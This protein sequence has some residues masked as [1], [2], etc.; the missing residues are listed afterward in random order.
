[1]NHDDRVA[2]SVSSDCAAKS[3]S[4]ATINRQVDYQGLDLLE[5]FRYETIADKSSLGP[6]R[7]NRCLD[8]S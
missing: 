1:M 7:N 4:S 5:Q 2:G 8:S 3:K 6:A